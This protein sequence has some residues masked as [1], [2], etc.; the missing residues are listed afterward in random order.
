MHYETEDTFVFLD[1][2]SEEVFLTRDE[3]LSKLS[4]VLASWPAEE[5]SPDLARFGSLTEAAEFLMESA[6]ELELG[7]GRGS[8][9]WFSVRLDGP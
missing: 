5:L 3:L 1:P 8:L 6:C 9:Q 7:S 4:E 2:D